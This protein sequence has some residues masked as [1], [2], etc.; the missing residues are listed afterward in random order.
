MKRLLRSCLVNF[1]ALWLTSQLIPS[2]VITGGIKGWVIAV[3]AFMLANL[4]LNPL[5]K[6]LLLPLNLLTLGIFAWLSNVIVLYLLVNVV[7]NIKLLPYAFAGA[8]LD[9][10]V[11]PAVDLTTFQVA[12]LVSF[13]IGLII[14]FTNWL[15]K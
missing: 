15:L 5:I 6:I 13:V 10:F 4:L 7:P 11:I 14:H 1:G 9:G 2:L 3:L 12:I 8:S